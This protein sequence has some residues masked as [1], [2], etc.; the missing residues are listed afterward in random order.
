MTPVLDHGEVAVKV[1]LLCVSV[2]LGAF[3]A[4]SWFGARLGQRARV[5][6]EFGTFAREVKAAGLL[7]R[8]AVRALL[9][10]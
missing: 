7:I 3:L 6:G 9:C 4:R 1:Q 2:A 10:R 8:G 5:G